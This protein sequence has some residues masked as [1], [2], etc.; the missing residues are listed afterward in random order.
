[1]LMRLEGGELAPFSRVY[2]SVSARV[3]AHH[4]CLRECG[5]EPTEIFPREISEDVIS[6]IVDRGDGMKFITDKIRELEAKIFGF[7]VL[8]LSD[9]SSPKE[10]LEAARFVTN[11]CEAKFSIEN[12]RRRDGN[13]AALEMWKRTFECHRELSDMAVTLFSGPSSKAV[14]DVIPELLTSLE[15]KEEWVLFDRVRA[16][17]K[18]LNSIDDDGF[19]L[20]EVPKSAEVPVPTE[21]HL[22]DT[23]VL[24]KNLAYMVSVLTIAVLAL[25]IMTHKD[26]S[27]G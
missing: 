6:P 4:R 17:Q 10:A 16:F 20:E 2:D 13:R 11:V 9:K 18:H 1:M 15:D 25:A 5:I 19:V 3:R 22:R 26:S 21:G 14:K 12:T 7:D 24:V 8:V 27:K 23:E